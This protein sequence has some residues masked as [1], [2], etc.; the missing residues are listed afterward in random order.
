MSINWRASLVPAAGG[1]ASC[2]LLS[3]NWRASLVPAAGGS[4]SCWL[5]NSLATGGVHQHLKE[6]L[7]HQFFWIG[8]SH[9]RRWFFSLMAIT[10]ASLYH[11]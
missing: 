2:W 11:Q 9:V 1:S 4:A 6:T 8:F 3:I 5:L 10:L 7:H